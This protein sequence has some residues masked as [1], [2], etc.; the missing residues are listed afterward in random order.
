M[1]PSLPSGSGAP[2]SSGLPSPSGAPEPSI[3][4]SPS[5]A[6]NTQPSN[7]P[8]EEEE[9][10]LNHEALV[11]KYKKANHG[12]LIAL[13]QSNNPNVTVADPQGQG[14]R[15][16]LP[17]VKNQPYVSNIA[18]ELVRQGAVGSYTDPVMDTNANKFL[19][20]AMRKLKPSIYGDKCTSTK[21]IPMIDPKII[22]KL[23]RMG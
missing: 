14:I 19:A 1:P 17:R 5:G 16:Y 12:R 13:S 6:A 11:A 4:P 15:G 7:P 23:K 22:T 21:C 18:D 10:T 9:L 20:D 8:V 2:S 3:L